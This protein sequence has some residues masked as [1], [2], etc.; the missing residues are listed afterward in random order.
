MEQEEVGYSSS[1]DIFCLCSYNKND[2]SMNLT[3]Q[4][5]AGDNPRLQKLS[6]AIAINGC[7]PEDILISLNQLFKLEGRSANGVT[8]SY[9]TRSVSITLFHHITTN[10][11]SSIPNWRIPAAGNSGGINLIKLK[12][13]FGFIRFGC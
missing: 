4:T 6:G 12:G 13:S 8:N 7:R 5:L 9:P 2:L 10:G 1:V 11:S 3:G